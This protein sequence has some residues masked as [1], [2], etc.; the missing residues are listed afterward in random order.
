ME[1]E[2]KQ[3]KPKTVK[4]KKEKVVIKELTFSQR[5]QKIREEKSKSKK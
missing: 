2:V 5:L 3:V 1:K 4:K